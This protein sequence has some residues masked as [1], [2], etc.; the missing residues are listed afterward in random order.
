M[1]LAVRSPAPPEGVSPEARLK[2][3]PVEA[4]LANSGVGSSPPPSSA[5]AA[6]YILVG[7]PAIANCTGT[8][9]VTQERAGR[10]AVYHCAAQK[11]FLF[12][13]TNAHWSVSIG[14]PAMSAGTSLLSSSAPQKEGTPPH[15][16]SSWSRG[17]GVSWT[18]CPGVAFLLSGRANTVDRGQTPTMPG[19]RQR[20]RR[21]SAVH[22]ATAPRP[23]TGAVYDFQNHYPKPYSAH[24]KG[25][26]FLSRRELVQLKA[27]YDEHVCNIPM[28]VGSQHDLERL[29]AVMYRTCVGVGVDLGQ[30]E[31]ALAEAQRI[32]AVA[33][34]STDQAVLGQPLARPLT[35][36]EFLMFCDGIKET[37]SQ[38]AVAKHGFGM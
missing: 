27:V 9:L 4:P 13:D 16:V 36:C 38:G 25:A 34:G 28:R 33:A 30:I 10:A 26:S 18:V 12:F 19:S 23:P 24:S 6:S 15:L 29:Q 3:R 14:R 17:D 35:L 7:P 20:H 11:A 8:Y 31:A 21:T 22:D 37:H 1:P 2:T 32:A 5:P